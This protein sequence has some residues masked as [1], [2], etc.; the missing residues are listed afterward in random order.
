ME[1]KKFD[2]AFFYNS[3]ERDIVTDICILIEKLQTRA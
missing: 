1:F 2:H 3:T